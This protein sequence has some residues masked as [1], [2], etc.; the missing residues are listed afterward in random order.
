[1]SG[2]W[3]WS[4]LLWVTVLSSVWASLALPV[5]S[6]MVGLLVCPLPDSPSLG[7]LDTPQVGY[8]VIIPIFQHI[9]VKQGGRFTW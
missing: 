3:G 1:M 6:A 9:Q 7:L 5:V 4:G 2:L 8:L